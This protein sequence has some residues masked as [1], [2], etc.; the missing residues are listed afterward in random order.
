MKQHEQRSLDALKRAKDFLDA[1]AGVI[2][3]LAR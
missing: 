2:G 3:A 1:N